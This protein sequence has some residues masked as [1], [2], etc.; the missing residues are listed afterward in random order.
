L[1]ERKTIFEKFVAGLNAFIR[2]FEDDLGGLWN[3]L[4]L[5]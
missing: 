1:L 2:T 3:L 5:E 4:L